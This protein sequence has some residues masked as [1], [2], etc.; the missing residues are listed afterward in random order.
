MG[1]TLVKDDTLDDE[2]RE[3]DPAAIY[4][5]DDGVVEVDL[6]APDLDFPW[7]SL[8]PGPRRWAPTDLS[9][10]VLDEELTVVRMTYR[11]VGDRYVVVCGIR[12][13]V[14]V[15]W[16]AERIATPL[17]FNYFRKR[18]ANI[19]PAKIMSAL[20]GAP[21]WE[22]PQEAGE[23]VLGICGSGDRPARLAKWEV[24][25]GAVLVATHGVSDAELEPLLGT[26][27]PFTTGGAVQED[28]QV[29]HRRAL[30]QRWWDAP[31]APWT[32]A[33]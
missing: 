10:E 19:P 27:E 31:R 30:A 9:V 20:K 33:G 11:T 25:D 6:V 21:T 14:D 18:Q 32:P 7:M 5:A 23:W 13:G 15:D 1:T 8:P 17:L 28:L 4:E 22:E 29:R 2:L 16:L 24:S 3:D 12:T 26:L